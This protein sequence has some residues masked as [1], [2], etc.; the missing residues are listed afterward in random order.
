MEDLGQNITKIE[1]VDLLNVIMEKKN[2][3]WRLAQICCAFVNHSE[4]EVSYSFA[5]DYE[6]EHY[7]LV[8]A[9]DEWVPS[10]SRVYRAAIFYENEMRELFGLD[11]EF[12]KVDYHDKLYRINEKI[13]FMKEE[14]S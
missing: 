11:V 2:D 10:I 7:R 1:K 12:M 13:P 4:Y 5:K 14:E 8:V 3:E 6:I 9:K